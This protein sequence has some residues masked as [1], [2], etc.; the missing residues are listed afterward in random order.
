[1]SKT[2][3]AVDI[4]ASSGRL[5]LSQINDQKLNLKE[6]HRFNNGFEKENGHDCWEIEQI[7]DEIF[8]GLEKVKALGYDDIVL[9]IDTWAVDY[10]LVGMDGIK[11]QNPVSYRD[12]RTKN[13]LKELTT[14][15]PK[16]LIYKNRN[17]IP[18][19]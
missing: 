16:S 11:I 17:S 8:K 7:I 3:V 10:V 19:F 6:I 2:Y 13:A 1:M 12:S 18:Q 15:V 5:M 9:G 4:G 14:D